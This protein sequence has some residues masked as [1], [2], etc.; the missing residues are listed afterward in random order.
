MNSCSRNHK[1]AMVRDTRD[2]K[3]SM[4][5]SSE[6]L[7]EIHSFCYIKYGLKLHGRCYKAL[8]LIAALLFFT[9]PQCLNVCN[10]SEKTYKS[11]S[12]Q[13][14]RI[15][16]LFPFACHLSLIILHLWH[17]IDFWNHSLGWCWHLVS[18][19]YACCST[20]K[21]SALRGAYRSVLRCSLETENTID[22]E[23]PPPSKALE[24]L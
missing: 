15:N 9:P 2:I 20:E 22:K 13:H 10:S 8:R 4:F 18:I 19:K 17:C 16:L 6:L 21:C 12:S 24:L 14:F 23:P 1:T 5:L 11:W 3:C 7:Y